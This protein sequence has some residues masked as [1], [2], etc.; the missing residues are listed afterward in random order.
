MRFQNLGADI[1][2]YQML[3]F[4]WYIIMR[5]IIYSSHDEARN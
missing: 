5:I 4:T 1:R 3:V 2:S